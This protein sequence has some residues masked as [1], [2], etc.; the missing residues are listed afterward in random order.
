MLAMA[1]FPLWWSAAAERTGRRTVYIISFALYV[2]S[3][4]CAAESVNI[5]MLIAFRV[6]SGATAASLQAV[7]AG[8]ISDIYEVQERGRAMGYFYLG[9]LCGPLLSP[10]V[11]GAL[12]QRFGWRST[13]WFLAIY[14]VVELLLMIF[15]LPE[16]LRHKPSAAQRLSTT[17]TNATASDRVADGELVHTLS[18]VSTRTRIAAR[19]WLTATREIVIDPLKALRFMQYPPVALTVTSAALTFGC[20]YVLNVSIQET[21]A[22][23][24]YNF[25]TLIVGLCYI[26]GSLGY[27]LA[28]ILGGK[29]TDH[30]MR[31]AALKRRDR[32]AAAGEVAPD[33]PLQYRPEDRMG[34]NAWVAG[35]M[36][37]LALIWYGWM[38]QKG[39][40]WFVPMMATFMFGIGSMLVFS[41]ATTMLTEFVPG[42]SASAVAV[43]NCTCAH[44]LSVIIWGQEM[45][46]KDY[47]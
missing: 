21:Y 43:N 44:K 4:I 1:I 22:R 38:V 17:A 7:G 45:L 24:P 12:T 42:R 47:P 23:A 9:P 26:P 5:G 6:A 14:G 31:A 20:L 35:L 16:T 2:A 28:S 13:Q 19:T 41:M 33:A 10:I 29:W 27:V 37:P 11:G 39:V 8:T 34:I 40:F 46:I 30:I 18:R 36:Y 25:S 15:C 3:S 32:M